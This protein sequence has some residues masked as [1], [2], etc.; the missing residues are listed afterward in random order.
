MQ[1]NVYCM[2]NYTMLYECNVVCQMQEDLNSFIF[3]INILKESPLNSQWL[4]WIKA[5]AIFLHII[6][7]TCRS[8]KFKNFFYRAFHFLIFFSAA[9]S[10]IQINCSEPSQPAL[11]EALAPIFNLSAIRPVM[12]LTTRTNVNMS[13][14]M[15]GI[16]G[17]V[18]FSS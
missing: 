5:Q 4:L 3:L 1:V 6:P 17:V 18:C 10:A 15:Y 14:I 2:H 11:L 8:I 16:L 7:V 13:F 12:N 9:D